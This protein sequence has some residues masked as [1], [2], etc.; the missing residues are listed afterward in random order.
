M[1]DSYSPDGF[2]RVDIVDVGERVVYAVLPPSLSDEE[3]AELEEV[4]ERLVYEVPSRVLLDRPLLLQRLKAL[5]VPDKLAYFVES[6]IFGYQWLEPLM[7]DENL[8]D[9]HCFKPGVPVRVVHR[10]HGL[11]QTNII[12]GE[13]EVDRMV[14]LLAYRGGKAVSLFQPVLDTVILPGGERASLTYRSEASE[15]SGFTVRKPPRDPWT[16]TRLITRGTLSP[17]CAALLWAAVDAKVPV[18]L[19]GPMRVGKTSLQNALVMAIPPDMVVAL[20]QDAPE[21]RTFHENLISLFTSRRVGFEDLAR[22]T[23]RRS[24]DYVVVNEVRVREEA[25]WWSQMVATGHGGITT[26]H[27]FDPERVFARLREME[28]GETLAE[29]VKVVVRMALFKAHRDGRPTRI[30]RVISVDY[31][32]GLANYKPV[33]ANA[34]AYD[35][36]SDTLVAGPG[37]DKLVSLLEE[38][39]KADPMLEDRARFLDLAAKLGFRGA[40]DFWGLHLKFRQDPDAIIKGLEGAIAR[41]GAKK[42]RERVTPIREIRYCPRCGVELPL[43]SQTCPRCGFELRV[44]AVGGAP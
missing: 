4:L 2:T 29:S 23:L 18:L 36:H 31:V 32:E 33:L 11:I 30:R 41:F 34:Y 14:R 8:E 15:A 40:E 20:V 17:D 38:A 39:F 1:L 22:L 13:E 10:D 12:P 26:M 16:L 19:Y 43:G 27:A 3:R 21:I 25:Y 44:L 37:L 5:G 35:F 24:V 28:V 42:P 6:R 7:R 9:I